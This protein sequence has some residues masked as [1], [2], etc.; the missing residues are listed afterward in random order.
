M[1]NS[2]IPEYDDIFYNYVKYHDLLK[3]IE[4]GDTPVEGQEWIGIISNDD[5]HTEWV[6][7]NVMSDPD[8]VII[9]P[10]WDEIYNGFLEVNWPNTEEAKM[11]IQNLVESIE[12]NSS[13][14]YNFIINKIVKRM[15]KENIQSKKVYVAIALGADQ[16]WFNSIERIN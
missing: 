5:T 9:D 14:V 16:S 7:E 2:V 13:A 8:A 6:S 1:R 3:H 10:N 11:Y 12:N 4:Y 15:K